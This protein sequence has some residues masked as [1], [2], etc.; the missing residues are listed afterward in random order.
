L[1]E[2]NKAPPVPARVQPT[3]KPIEAPLAEVAPTGAP[4]EDTHAS[5]SSYPP[6][7]QTQ[8]TPVQQVQKA[9]ANAL[10][11]VEVAEKAAV[12]QVAE[13]AAVEQVAEKAAYKCGWLATAGSS[14]WFVL[15][16]TNLCWYTDEQSV[17]G[18]GGRGEETITRESFEAFYE[19]NSANQD[20]FDKNLAGIGDLLQLNTTQEVLDQLQNLYKCTPTTTRVEVGEDGEGGEGGGGGRGGQARSSP[21]IMVVDPVEGREVKFTEGTALAR[22]QGANPRSFQVLSQAPAAT[23]VLTASDTEEMEAWIEAIKWNLGLLR[24][25]ATQVGEGG[26]EQGAAGAGEVGTD[27]PPPLASPPHSAPPHAPPP[28]ASPPHSAPP[29]PP[30]LASPPHAPSGSS[31]G[32]ALSAPPPFTSQLSADSIADSIASSGE[33]FSA[34]ELSA[35]APHSSSQPARSESPWRKSSVQL[36]RRG[37]EVQVQLGDNNAREA[38]ALGR[39][40]SSDSS[41]G[42]NG[43]SGSFSGGHPPEPQRKIS[44]LQKLFAPADPV[45][46]RAS[47]GASERRPSLPSRAAPSPPVTPQS[48]SVSKLFSS[49]RAAASP[50]GYTSP[51]GY[52]AAT[53][54][55]AS[56]PG[57]NAERR[58]S[59][60]EK[61]DQ[62]W[63][64]WDST[65]SSPAASP[66]PPTMDPALT[67]STSGSLKERRAS[68]I[69]P[70]RRPPPPPRASPR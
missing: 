11:P 64:N 5:P 34:D 19:D 26:Q 31:S 68:V 23:H 52:G 50:N 7:I 43:T 61:M 59:H 37:S 62:A 55:L 41:G 51:N 25:R 3:A 36:E 58:Q 28:L 57:N 8:S 9:T 48:G 6:P 54:G 2:E 29:V 18:N 30:P 27:V 17:H 47:I 45:L 24:W 70:K 35:C 39:A 15:E 32:G 1:S 38:E 56:S 69:K 66:G 22:Q 10:E 4:G 49:A 44:G 12:E 67:R 40:I 33:D 42:A 65:D 63:Q 14:W 53:A 46:R 60:A 21:E 13:K 20:S 16:A